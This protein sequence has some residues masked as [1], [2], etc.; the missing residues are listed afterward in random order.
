MSYAYDHASRGRE[1]RGREIIVMNRTTSV[2]LINTE[3]HPD[4]SLISDDNVADNG[5]YLSEEAYLPK[6]ATREGGAGN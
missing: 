5:G 2:S 4:Q 6:I 3:P 1:A